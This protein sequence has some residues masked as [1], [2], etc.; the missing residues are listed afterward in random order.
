M[1]SISNL[2]PFPCRQQFLLSNQ[3]MVLLYVGLRLCPPSIQSEQGGHEGP[4]CI[5]IY[6]KVS[7]FLFSQFFRILFCSRCCLFKCPDFL[8]QCCI[9]MCIDVRLPSETTSSAWHQIVNDTR[10]VAVL[11]LSIWLTLLPLYTGRQFL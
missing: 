7:L 5:S 2:Q 11:R 6:N 4:V 10:V 1:L 8:L 3:L 9:Y